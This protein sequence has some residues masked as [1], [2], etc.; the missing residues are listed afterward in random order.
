MHHF[1][2]IW[3]VTNWICATD[4]YSW[5]SPFPR[6]AFLC[7]CSKA[8]KNVKLQEISKEFFQL[9][10]FFFRLNQSFKSLVFRGLLSRSENLKKQ[11]F[12]PWSFPKNERKFFLNS[13]L[14]SNMGQVKKIIIV[15]CALIFFLLIHFSPVG[16]N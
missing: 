7:Y 9:M 11:F 2:L 8:Y 1:W 10:G 14:A 13:A 4:F 6:S 12:L 3:S 5:E 15:Q 16:Q